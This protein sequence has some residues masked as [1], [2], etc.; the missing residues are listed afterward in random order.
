MKYLLSD[1][2]FKRSEERGIS[3]EEIN[4]AVTVGKE[5]KSKLYG[6]QLRYY[7]SGICVV[8]RKSTNNI[9]TVYRLK[10]H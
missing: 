8:V 7:H 3:I 4:A 5:Y 9:L 10:H 2:A 1:H 6:G